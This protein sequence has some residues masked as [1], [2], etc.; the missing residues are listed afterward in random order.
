MISVWIPPF[1][2]VTAVVGFCLAL[3]NTHEF[4]NCLCGLCFEGKRPVNRHIVFLPVITY[5][6]MDTSD[7]T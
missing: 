7:C 2:Y 1:P 3:F 5:Q 6:L 4:T